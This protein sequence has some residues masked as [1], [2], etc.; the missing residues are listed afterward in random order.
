MQIAYAVPD[1]HAA[2]PAW[3]ERWGAEGWVFAD[4][5]ELAEV[6]H[7][8]AAA[9]LDHSSAYGRAGNVMVELITVHGAEPPSLQAAV[10][11]DGPGVHHVAR[12]ADDL[13][14]AAAALARGGVAEVARAVT[15][16]GTRFAW[17]DARPR[18]GHL[19]ELYERSAPLL[20]FY[21]RLGV[22]VT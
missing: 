16:G 3:T 20:A 6:I 13:D 12:F 19:L 14:G 22:P 1:P 2:A 4:H 9:A 5:I 7:G 17:L 11:T 18:L 8:G 15:T 21:E 10:T